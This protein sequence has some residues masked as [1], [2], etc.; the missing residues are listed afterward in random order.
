MTTLPT[1][2]LPDFSKTFEVT[3]DASGIRVGV[4]LSQGDHPITFFS[5]KM[6]PNMQSSYAYTREPYAITEAVRKW[7]QYLLGRHFNIY[8]D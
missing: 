8:T 3:T 7:C 1:L 4:V 5:K 2:A 6:G